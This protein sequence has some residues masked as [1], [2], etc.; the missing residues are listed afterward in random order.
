MDIDQLPPYGFMRKDF[1]GIPLA[2]CPL[3]WRGTPA[4]WGTWLEDLTTL[5]S[6]NVWPRYDPGGGWRAG[7]AKSNAMRLTKAELRL[8]PQFAPQFLKPPPRMLSGRPHSEFFKWEDDSGWPRSLTQYCPELPAT[9][10]VE[11]MIYARL[12]KGGYI[13]HQL[14]KRFQRPRPQQVSML[15]DPTV[16]FECIGASTAFTPSMVSGHAFQG[17]MAACSV[18]ALM[19][20]Y[21]P[22]LATRDEM[23]VR[24]WGGDIGD[25]RVMAGVHYPADSIASWIA[26]LELVKHVF[27]DPD[28][29]LFLAAMIE[30]SLLYTF[31]DERFKAGGPLEDAEARDAYAPAWKCLAAGLAR[32]RQ[33]KGSP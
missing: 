13:P 3:H 21:D 25:R 8:M 6:D 31:L 15:L 1:E 22:K 16:K 18:H 26:A 32:A 28:M 17:L 4:E 20:S 27:D 12:Y 29:P 10:D 11:W 24:Q 33:R 5:L 23:R 9:T 2:E 14:K 19:K 7:T 30:N